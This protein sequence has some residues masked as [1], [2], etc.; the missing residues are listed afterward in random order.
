M[1]P[2]ASATF[3][4]EIEVA[5]EIHGDTRNFVNLDANGIIEVLS[6]KL[7]IPPRL[8]HI[9]G[10]AKGSVVLAIQLPLFWSRQ[11][12]KQKLKRLVKAK[13]TTWIEK[14]NIIGLHVAEDMDY[15]TFEKQPKGKFFKPM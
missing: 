7:G 4:T 14:F 15:F 2:K 12:I 5:Y 6:K 8:V 13:D 3:V 1:F 11:D 10:V 9:V